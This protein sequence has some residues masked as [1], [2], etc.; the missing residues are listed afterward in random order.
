M[1]D[2]HKVNIPDMPFEIKMPEK[3][4]GGCSILMVGSTRCGKTTALKHILKKYFP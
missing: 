1:S 4:T 3:A 2:D